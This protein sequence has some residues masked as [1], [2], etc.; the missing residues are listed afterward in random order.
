[1]AD[2]AFFQLARDRFKRCAEHEDE[3]RKSILAA[4]EFRA[5][6]Q[7]PDDIRIQ[8]QGGAAIQGQAAQPPR[9]CLTIDRISQPIRQVSNSIRAANF[10]I[11]V[12]PNGHG[13][14]DDT[15]EIYKGLIRRIQN[16]ARDEAPI[17]WA[18]DQAAE[19][20]LGW[21]RILTEYV[22]E[23]GFDQD[24]RLSRVTNNLSVYCDPG[25]VKPTKSDAQFMFVTEDLP[26]AE[27]ERLYGKEPMASLAE[28]SGT[29][30][31]GGWVT[32]ETVRIAEYWRIEYDKV[33]IQS[34][35]GT[36]SRTAQK[37][38]VLWSKIDALTEHEKTEWAGTHIP[39]IPILGEELN[40]DG[41][42]IVRGVTQPAMDPQRMVNYNFSA[43]V[44]AL[45][46]APKAPI[47]A[48][49][50]Q[51]EPY[52]DIYQNA[53]RWNYSYIPYVP[54]VV[55]STV[56]PPPFRLAADPNI[57]PMIEMLRQSEEA[58]KATTGIFDPS[59]GNT[60][61]REKSGRAIQ[62]L[63]RQ[64]EMGQS[65]Y[66]DNVQRALI[67]AGELLVEIIPKYY[68]S[69]GRIVQILGLDDEPQQVMLN[70]PH[71]LD[72]QGRPQ[73]LPP[74]TPFQNGLHKFYDM[75]RGKYA[76]T[77]SV[78]K[79]H[80]TRREEGAA[81]LG[82]LIGAA[83]Q[84]LPVLG[85][86]FVGDMDFPG[87]QD[88]AERLK[89]M[90]PPPL[91]MQDGQPTAEMM[92]PQL[93]QQLQQ[94]GKIIEELSAHVTELTKRDQAKVTQEEYETK[95]TSM[96]LE[97]KKELAMISLAG[98][99]ATAQAKIDAGHAEQFIDAMENR[100]SGVLDLHMQRLDHLHEQMMAGAQQ[101][102]E[103]EQADK[104]LAQP[105]PAGAQ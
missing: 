10:A 94:G 86:L 24:V 15:A 95:R 61:P 17:D 77:V 18:G 35:D 6:N 26:K 58:I 97:S 62:A 73:E 40:V 47:M 25:A 100:L 64:S 51:V 103:A 71:Q 50:E 27:Y 16:Q 102:H 83:P 23:E 2:T 63:Q 36:K 79:S 96:E 81:M 22:D 70:A 49:A 46:L 54:Q 13:A 82:E 89:K 90:L 39:L 72:S 4:K 87:A 88:A 32:Q 65:N 99:L 14:D 28:F 11:D 48:T 20:G 60:N 5:G 74:E 57:A 76:V 75:K 69:P 92:V 104:A 7:W 3:Q 84:L 91:Q 44:E 59:L 93:Q 98:T 8:R 80:T 67:Y 52:K 68:D 9:P 66:L 55:M 101:A 38:K 31:T 41:K 85:D 12:M 43:A 37:P 34:Q 29:G 45:A 21:F 53:N 19:G 30:D 105:E 42:M 56:L 78:G 33:E 1:M